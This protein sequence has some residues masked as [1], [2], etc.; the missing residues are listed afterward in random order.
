M[1]KTYSCIITC[2]DESEKIIQEEII[3]DS[4]IDACRLLIT[5]KPKNGYEIRHVMIHQ[6]NLLL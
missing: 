6:E 4:V 3:C 1:K 5:Y 2:N